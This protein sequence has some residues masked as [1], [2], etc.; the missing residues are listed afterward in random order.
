MKRLLCPKRHRWCGN[1]QVKVKTRRGPIGGQSG[2]SASGAKYLWFGANSQLLKRITRCSHAEGIS[3][4][5]DIQGETELRPC[6]DRQSGGEFGEDSARRLEA[7]SEKIL[8]VDDEE[9][10]LEACKRLLH[11]LFQMDT[12]VGGPEGI[13]AVQSKGPYAVVLSDMQMPRMD[14]IQFLTKVKIL[15]PDTIRIMLTGHADVQTALN[16]V[17]EGNIFRFLTKPCGKQTLITAL[18]AGLTQYRLI[19]SEKDIL[20]KTLAGSISVLTEVLSMAS[21]AAFSRAMRLRRYMA[22][23]VT[24]LGLPNA[25]KFELA[26]MLSQLG[27]VTMP[28]ETVDAVY[29]GHQL[30]PKELAL[31]NTHPKIACDLLKN[32]PRLESVAWMIAHQNEPTV[33]D[34]DIS[35]PDTVEMRL[36]AELLA[37]TLAFDARVRGGD[38][39]ADAACIVGRLHKNS[40]PRIMLA[41]V[42]VEPEAD[43]KEVHKCN[44]AS[45]SPGM[46]IDREV[47]TGTGQL[48]VAK[49]QEVT[50]SVV[51]KLKNYYEKGILQGEI[52]VSVPATATPAKHL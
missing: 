27:C 41:L 46:V 32:I 31:Y 19:T 39:R 17:N 22:N 10:V 2:S 20:E 15:A 33:V 49:N 8:L 5:A 28:P 6:G 7:M 43:Q 14:G 12:A 50:P 37:I 38:S 35:N 26:A 48:I 42:E 13:E 18:T 21:P 44:I 52:L 23:V 47:R 29:T 9:R 16:A 3:Q 25:W 1:D 36:G 4:L 11:N 34:G 51:M 30:P 40:D 24:K 45:L